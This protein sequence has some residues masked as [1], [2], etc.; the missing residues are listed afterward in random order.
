MYIRPDLKRKKL[1]GFILVV[2]SSLGAWLTGEISA[3]VAITAIT[4]AASVYMGA[5]GYVDGKKAEAAKL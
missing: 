1:W 5:Q 2:V 4:S 3:V